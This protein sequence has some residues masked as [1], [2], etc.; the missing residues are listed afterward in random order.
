MAKPEWGQKRTCLG[1]GTRFYDMQNDPIVCPS[2]EA[3]F[4]PLALV[5]P[6]R[7][8]AAAA[9][10][11]K[12]K[13]EAKAAAPEEAVSEDEGILVD[14]DADAL[15]VDDDIDLGDDDD[16]LLPDDDDDSDIEGDPD[17]SEA[18]ENAKDG[19]EDRDT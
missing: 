13:A 1:C 9:S 15:V 18:L 10:Q 17:V 4:D 2:C 8:R 14:D 3:E 16:D 5:R 19:D 11:A 7:A 12:A 6:R